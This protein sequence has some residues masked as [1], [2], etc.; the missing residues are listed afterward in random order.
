[1]TTSFSVVPTDLT[2]RRPASVPEWAVSVG[3]TYNLELG[4]DNELIFHTDYLMESNTQIAEGL[5][6]YRR[7]VEALNAS[8]T[9]ALGNGLSVTAWGRNLTDD[10]YTT[11]IFPSVAQAGSLSGYRNQ[12]PTYGGSVKFKF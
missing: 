2:G 12:P 3:G 4:G 5:S 11:T 7:A 1:M 6:Q 10:V 8:V 9:L